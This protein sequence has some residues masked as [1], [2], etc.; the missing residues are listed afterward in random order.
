PVGV[1][2]FV[3]PSGIAYNADIFA[4]NGWPA[5]TSWLDLVNPT[6]GKCLVPLDPNQGVPWIPMLN[7]VTTGDWANAT[8][9]F[10]MLKAVAPGVQSWSNTNPSRLG[11][12][13]K[14]T[15]C[16]TPTS[17]GRFIEA[18]ITSPSLKYATLKEGPV[19]FGGTLTITKLA[20]HPIAAQMAV[21]TLLSEESGNQLLQVSYFPSVNTKV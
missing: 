12:V 13:A 2:I 16:M 20:P 8:K 17:Q 10:A 14:G 4:K 6:Y 3:I 5:P 18:S 7:Y 19:V 1:R 21:N 15:G 11:L 9:T